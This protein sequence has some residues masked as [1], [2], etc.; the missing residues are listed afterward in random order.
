MSTETFSKA[1][2]YQRNYLAGESWHCDAQQF[3]D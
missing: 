3:I 1:A 2:Q